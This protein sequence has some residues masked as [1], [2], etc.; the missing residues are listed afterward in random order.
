MQLAATSTSDTVASLSKDDSLMSV[1][2]SNNSHSATNANDPLV[3][4]PVGELIYQINA[5][6]EE[7]S[8]LKDQ[9]AEDEAKKAQ[10]KEL[11]NKLQK[12]YMENP[13][14]KAI[15]KRSLAHQYEDLFKKLNLSSEENDEFNEVLFEKQLARRE[16]NMAYSDIEDLTPEQIE[17]R[18]NQSQKIEEE[19]DQKI[20]ELLGE[21]DYETYNFYSETRY[22]RYQV[23]DYSG[24]LDADNA[25]T[26]S[27]KESLIEAM[28]D[29]I[30]YIVYDTI[31]TDGESGGDDNYINRIEIRTT[32][33]EKEYNAYLNA[34]AGILS[35]SQIEAFEEYIEHEREQYKT[36]MEMSALQ[37]QIS[38]AGNNSDEDGD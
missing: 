15:M 34:A 9:L 30:Q 25:L 21:N 12:Q 10:I 16:M 35:A 13:Y 5:A 8:T 7:L 38:E 37:Y 18:S 11:R 29:E 17:E 6:E 22:L 2:N 27:Q 33:Q 1:E 19:A 32:N 36:M 4:S 24:Y 3:D 26:D 23:S 14:Y 28:H 31:E 20:K